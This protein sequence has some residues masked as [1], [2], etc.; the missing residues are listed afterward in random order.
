M[1]A[2][3]TVTGF[4]GNER[5]SQQHILEKCW[6]PSTV[7]EPASLQLHTSMHSMHLRAQETVCWH[8]GRVNDHHNC[9]RK[10]IVTS[11]Y[12]DIHFNSVLVTTGTM[13][14]YMQPIQFTQL[15]VSWHCLMSGEIPGEGWYIVAVGQAHLRL[16]HNSN[17]VCASLCKKELEEHSQSSTIWPPMGLLMCVFLTKPS[18]SDSIWVSW[19]SRLL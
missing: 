11:I 14:W 19:G 16:W 4:P 17:S 9:S 12:L 7:N 8:E 13:R 6:R 5:K 18:K 3:T 15:P 10:S 2:C 1:N